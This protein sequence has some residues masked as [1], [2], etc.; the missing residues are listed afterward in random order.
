MIKR[1]KFRKIDR[2]KSNCLNLNSYKFYSKLTIRKIKRIDNN[3]KF[4][5]AELKNYK[6]LI[7]KKKRNRHKRYGLKWKYIIE[8][9][10]EKDKF[11]AIKNFYRK[12]QWLYDISPVP[13]IFQRYCYN[14]EVNK[15]VKMYLENGDNP[16]KS[17]FYEK[18]ESMLENTDTPDGR[19]WYG[20]GINYIEEHEKVISRLNKE[21]ETYG[22]E[23]LIIKV[24][25]KTFFKNNYSENYDKKTFV[26]EELEL[27]PRLLKLNGGY[28]D[29]Y[30]IRSEDYKKLFKFA[31]FHYQVQYEEM[32]NYYKVCCRL[33]PK[34][35]PEISDDLFNRFFELAREREKIIWNEK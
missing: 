14:H 9:N 19:L 35:M 6:N 28:I 1:I 15:A 3:L 8:T 32:L 29:L 20:G 4:G 26:I 30:M 31:M 13:K 25:E 16:D 18:S 34:I 21:T 24:G 7:I 23:K 22:L 2:D 27:V 5:Y 10:L 11:E 33:Y 17:I 12:E